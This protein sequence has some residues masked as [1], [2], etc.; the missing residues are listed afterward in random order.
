MRKLIDKIFNKE[1]RE[2]YKRL[3]ELKII[4]IDDDFYYYPEFVFLVTLTNY[5]M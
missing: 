1:K 4:K 2:F 3:E 5:L